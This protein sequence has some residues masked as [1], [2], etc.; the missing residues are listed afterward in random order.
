MQVSL[1]RQTDD[2]T[3]VIK[4]YFR[5]ET[6]TEKYET[7]NAAQRLNEGYAKVKKSFKEFLQREGDLNGFS[8]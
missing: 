8:R 3:K 6:T 5:N 2:G 7:T 4:T 1:E